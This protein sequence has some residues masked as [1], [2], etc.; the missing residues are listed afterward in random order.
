MLKKFAKE[1]SDGAPMSH[2]QPATVACKLEAQSEYVHIAHTSFARF[3]ADLHA[4][5]VLSNR[6]FCIGAQEEVY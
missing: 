3:G 5:S 4:Q 1:K 2:A 6:N